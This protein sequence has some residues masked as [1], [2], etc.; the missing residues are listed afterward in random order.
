[1]K[2]TNKPWPPGT[3]CPQ[4]CV[5]MLGER[6]GAELS[7]EIFRPHSP[8]NHRALFTPSPAWSLCCDTHLRSWG[9]QPYLHVS[10]YP[11]SL[12]AGESNSSLRSSSSFWEKVRLN[13]EFQMR[14]SRA[15]LVE[16]YKWKLVF[17]K[18]LVWLSGILR[19]VAHK[20]VIMFSNWTPFCFFCTTWVQN[21]RLKNYHENPSSWWFF[22]SWTSISGWWQLH[23]GTPK[24]PFLSP[25][26]LLYVYGTNE[27]H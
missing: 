4:L 7:W 23:K 3:R 25:W 19:H 20:V 15:S 24:Q 14:A 5:Y 1:M 17:R 27:L 6:G 11:P 18:M 16:E 22:F 12:P 10:K 2:E 9:Q 13:R 8:T 26:L 21:L